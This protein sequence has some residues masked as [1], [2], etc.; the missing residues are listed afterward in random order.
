MAVVQ[1]QRQ[2]LD[3]LLRAFLAQG[4]IH[5]LLT[6]ASDC[7]KHGKTT[8]GAPR[9]TKR[10]QFELLD[11]ASR[12]LRPARPARAE[13][14]AAGKLDHQLRKTTALIR[15]A[16][17]SRRG[18]GILQLVE[19]CED[20]AD[21]P[22]LW[23]WLDAYIRIPA[24]DCRSRRPPSAVLFGLRVLRIRSRLTDIG[25]TNAGG[26]IS[27]FDYLERTRFGKVVVTV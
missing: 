10:S 26:M 13:T 15:R 25:K 14:E 18:P 16:E 7:S 8:G 2:Y 19:P 9:R 5:Q 17:T 3:N 24:T 4:I 22:G 20:L 21:Q 1:C 11:I 6:I 27:R 12:K 23:L